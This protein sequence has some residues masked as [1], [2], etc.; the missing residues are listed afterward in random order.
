MVA[1]TVNA[2]T[3]ASL[4]LSAVLIVSWAFSYRVAHAADDLSRELVQF[5]RAVCQVE[6]G[7]DHF[8][9]AERTR[10]DGVD[11]YLASIAGEPAPVVRLTFK[12]T[13]SP[14]RTSID[15]V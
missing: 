14:R 12:V 15:R 13:V 3:V 4:L 5:A 9:R 7:E 8:V 2:A 1:A 6:L 10:I 11:A